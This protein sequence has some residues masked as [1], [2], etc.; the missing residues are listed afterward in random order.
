[1]IF[2]IKKTTK[3]VLTYADINTKV[4][5]TYNHTHSNANSRSH[6]PSPY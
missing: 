6:G 3:Y 2:F 4:N 5:K 1:M